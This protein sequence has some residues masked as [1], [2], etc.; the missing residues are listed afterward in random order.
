MTIGQ[1]D[2]INNFNS[3][4]E[5]TNSN[6]TAALL[7]F[8]SLFQSDD[9]NLFQEFLQIYNGVNDY[10]KTISL[11]AKRYN[12]DENKD[13]E[14]IMYLFVQNAINNGV[15]YH[16]NS[17]ANFES[18]MNMGIGVSAIGFKTEERKD[19]EM[20]QKSLPL[21]TLKKLLPFHGE[22]NG[23]KIYFSCTPILNA[24]YGDRPEWLKEL[25]LN[26][27]ILDEGTKEKE[28]VD[29]V[30]NKYDQK[31]SNA[32]KVLFIIPNPNTLSESTIKDSLKSESP[33]DII[34]KCLYYLE[35]KDMFTN[36]HI[37]SSYII[38]MDLNNQVLYALNENGVVD[39]VT[40][41]TNIGHSK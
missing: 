17:S 20:L 19:Y 28:I 16:L 40:Q 26:S 34:F 10:N 25:K 39:S 18:I 29:Q 35:E 27:F 31:Y 9:E 6:N 2:L 15:V 3:L 37:P 36:K 41:N 4:K 38:A 21:D 1:V 32:E 22:K 23:S 11:F 8:C 33:R 13:I 12:L 30:L 5:K 14:Q 7:R 24:R